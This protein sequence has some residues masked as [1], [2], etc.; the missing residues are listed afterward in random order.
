MWEWVG[1]IEC[2]RERERL[3]NWRR[4]IDGEIVSWIPNQYLTS[5]QSK[6]KC[7]FVCFFA[8]MNWFLKWFKVEN[9]QLILLVIRLQ[10]DGFL[11]SFSSLFFFHPCIPGPG[12][13]LHLPWHL[14][15]KRPGGSWGLHRGN[16]GEVHG[17]REAEAETWPQERRGHGVVRTLRQPTD[18]ELCAS[19][20]VGLSL[21]ATCID[22]QHNCCD[23][24]SISVKK[25]ALIS[26]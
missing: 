15:G 20:C 6:G 3:C 1:E 22:W 18:R 21:G 2:Q 16:A 19:M 4:S 17:G 8:Q 13:D 26:V 12:P 10:R 9:E 25:K 11:C 5:L 24:T 23:V 14:P 7:M